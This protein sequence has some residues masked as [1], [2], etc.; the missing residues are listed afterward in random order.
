LTLLAEVAEVTVSWLPLGLGKVGEET[1]KEEQ[2]GE[3][4]RRKCCSWGKMW[5]TATTL[6]GS[7]STQTTTTRL[8]VK[9]VIA[10][11]EYLAENREQVSCV[12]GEGERVR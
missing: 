1:S 9:M 12:G 4:V 3:W 10:N 8:M 5:W 2:E 7:L 6:A 11:D